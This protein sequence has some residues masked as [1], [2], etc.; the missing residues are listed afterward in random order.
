MWVF[1]SQMRAFMVAVG[2]RIV[3]IGCKNDGTTVAK[4]SCADGDVRKRCRER[5]RRLMWFKP[6]NQDRRTYNVFRCWDNRKY[7]HSTMQ[8]SLFA[9]SKSVEKSGHDM[10]Q[11]KALSVWLLSEHLLI[12][13]GYQIYVGWRLGG[14]SKLEN[15]ICVCSNLLLQ[16]Q[17]L[18]EC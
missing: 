1:L 16:V 11:C 3:A 6:V 5:S 4:K 2:E 17:W 14:L 7:S 9:G 15:C 12:H 13:G 18:L 10:F 8:N